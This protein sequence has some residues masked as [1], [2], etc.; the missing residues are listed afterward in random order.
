VTR[1]RW[2]ALC[3]GALLAGVAT[4]APGPST[5]AVPAR[6]QGYFL[7]A[8]RITQAVNVPGEHAGQRLRRAWTFFPRCPSGPCPRVALIRGG[9]RGRTIVLTTQ[10]PGLY[11]GSGSFPAPVRCAGHVFG[12][13]E[14]VPFTITVR[15]T[16]TEPDPSGPVATSI[17]AAYSSPSR[18]NHTRC[19]AAPSR[20]SATY[21]QQ[22]PTLR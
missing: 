6:L 3:A 18:T 14:T 9:T 7:L 4:V 1:A 13:G 20:E 15:I 16:G 2:A 21:R 5:A 8:G 11:T 10:G 19:V 17:R 22:A 12:A